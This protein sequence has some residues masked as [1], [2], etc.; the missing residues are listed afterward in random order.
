M[1][2]SGTYIV[3]RIENGIA[4]C[5]DESRRMHDIPLANLPA[6][7]KPGSVL[8]FRDGAFRLEEDLEQERRRR[9]LEL[10]AKLFHD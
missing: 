2:P 7:T 3:D 5:E 10:E 1:M 8:S 4:V 9:I 6:G